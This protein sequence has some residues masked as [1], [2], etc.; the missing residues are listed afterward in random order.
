MKKIALLAAALLAAPAAQAHVLGAWYHQRD[1]SSKLEIIITDKSSDHPACGG[2]PEIIA[3]NHWGGMTH[4][5]GKGCW[6][7][8]PDDDLMRV[9][10]YTYSTGERQSYAIDIDHI[11]LTDYSE[12]AIDVTPASFGK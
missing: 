4:P 7:K 1:D 6:K 8:T 12:R 9:D 10:L 5:Y 11:Y 3:F 2:K